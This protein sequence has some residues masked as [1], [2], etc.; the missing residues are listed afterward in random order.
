LKNSPLRQ[1]FFTFDLPLRRDA[2]AGFD[3]KDHVD[4]RKSEAPYDCGLSTMRLSY[5]FR[6]FCFRRFF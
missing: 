5:F 6:F 2:L 1:Q 3:V 4:T